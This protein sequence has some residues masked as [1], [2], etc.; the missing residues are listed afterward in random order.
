M[1]SSPGQTLLVRDHVHDPQAGPL[2]HGGE[3]GGLVVGVAQGGEGA[4]LLGKVGQAGDA[5]K[6]E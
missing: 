5:P 6:Q 1:I 4:I 2:A 3:L